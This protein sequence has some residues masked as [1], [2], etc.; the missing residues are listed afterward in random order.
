MFSC[1]QKKTG[2]IWDLLFALVSK[3]AST[4]TT[5]EFKSKTQSAASKGV[6]IKG[7]HSSRIRRCFHFFLPI[8]R[9]WCFSFRVF[10]GSHFS[11]RSLPRLAPFFR[12]IHPL[13]NETRELKKFSHS[14]RVTPSEPQNAIGLIPG[15]RDHV[16]ILHE[17]L[18]HCCS[19]DFGPRR[20]SVPRFVPI[21]SLSVRSCFRTLK[22]LCAVKKKEMSWK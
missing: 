20:P 4:G 7:R 11:Q 5:I 16:K 1:F 17:T 21:S 13:K 14:Q 2:S 18:S 8:D 15:E 6:L 9:N 19:P 22:K 3:S 12:S 10:N